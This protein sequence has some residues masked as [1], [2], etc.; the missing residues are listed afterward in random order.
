M[1]IR[2][3]IA[4]GVRPNDTNNKK[5]SNSDLTVN[6]FLQIMA[7]EIKN[8]TPLD[9]G[10]GGASSNS[11]YMTQMAQ[12]TSLEQMG[13]ITE[14]LNVLTLMS[15]QQYAFSLIG[16]EVTVMDEEGVVTGLVDKVKFENG[17][18]VFQVNDKT[19]NLGS[20]IEVTNAKD[21]DEN[22]NIN[23]SEENS[24]INPEVSE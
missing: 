17:Y 24:N 14:S 19:Y 9:S 15:Q 3:Y 23:D 7:A 12:F 4:N 10:G 2:N 6:D 5:S 11:S 1:E 20:V 13:A 8:Q 21:T 18:A 16:K 22:P